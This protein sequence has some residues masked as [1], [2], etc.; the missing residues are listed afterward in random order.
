MI[1]YSLPFLIMKTSPSS[2]SWQLAQL[3][4]FLFI[5][6]AGLKHIMISYQWGVKEQVLKLRQRLKTAGYRVWIDVE[7]MCKFYYNLNGAF[8][9]LGSLWTR[10]MKSYDVSVHRLANVKV[11]GF[12][13]VNDIL[14]WVVG[15]AW[16]LTTVNM[17]WLDNRIDLISIFQ[18]YCCCHCSI[19]L[20]LL[21]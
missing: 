14:S 8:S 12:S 6:T 18:L 10:H 16:L 4:I 15:Y 21:L 13:H 2:D 20:L 5:P 17:L 9:L 7:Q 11:C 1:F 3:I 19:L